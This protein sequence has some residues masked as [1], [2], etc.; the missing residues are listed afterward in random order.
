MKKRILFVGLNPFAPIGNSGMMSAILGQVD[1]DQF[2]VTCFAADPQPVEYLPLMFKP[3]PFSLISAGDLHDPQGKGKLVNILNKTPVDMLVFVGID[4]WE[5]VEIFNEI[6]AARIKN[7]F[8]WAWIFP[9]DLQSVRNDWV[10]W[11]NQLDYPCV[12]SKYGENILKDHVK[13]IRYFRPQLRYPEIWK[14]MTQ[15]ERI[16]LKSRVFP[17]VPSDGFLFGFIGGNQFRKDPQGHVKAFALAKA[18]N[19]NLFLFMHTNFSDG[20]F[21]LRQAGLDYGLT[22]N[23]LL[24]KPSDM[25]RYAVDAMPKLYNAFDCLVNCSLQEGLSWTPLEAMLCGVPVI[26]SDSTAHTELVSGAGI[27]VPCNVDTLL[28]TRTVGGPSYVDAKKCLPEDIAK[29]MLQVAGDPE[30][31]A[32]MIEKGLKKSQEWLDGVSDINDLLHEAC[33][34]ESVGM[35]EIEQE[36]IGRPKIEKI[37]AVLFAQHSAAGDVFMTTRCFKGIKERYNLPIHYMT[38]PPYIDILKN[39]PYIDEIIPWNEGVSSKY[40]VVLNPHGDRILPGHWGRNSNSILSD[41]YWKILNV[42]PDDFFIEL[43]RPDRLVSENLDEITFYEKDDDDV[44]RPFV[45]TNIPICILHTT[46]GDSHFRVYK[47]M[48]DVVERIKDTYTTVQLGGTNDYPAWADVDLRGK[49]NFRESAWIMSKATVAV[50]IDSF[51]S[52]LA[53]A[54]GVSQVCLFGS[55]NH[56]VV[57]PNQISG[58]LICR[59]IDYTRRCIGLGPCSAAVRDCP[60]TCTG[61]HRP[62]DII[63]DIKELETN[64]H[65]KSVIVKV[66]E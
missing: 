43:K 20:V 60:A 2:D 32:E 62:E 55:G 52:H 39:N 22:D 33:D 27:L 24:K 41:F 28:P 49:L 7:K 3:L 17:T 40:K 42:K 11:I 37:E 16:G 56:I 1:T 30:L 35:V 36:K 5:Y 47:Y 58:K 29:A 38:M 51:I 59:T 25:H 15:R 66:S 54:L 14:P 34:V 10:E 46:G 65:K 63:E 4:I 48:K 21:N 31:R 8:K 9:Y 44:Y 53:G 26:A 61:M 23:T 13:H 19:E 64:K 57:R 50:T 12:Y 18:K 45:T 6:N